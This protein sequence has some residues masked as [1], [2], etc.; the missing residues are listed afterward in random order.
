MPR[1]GAH[2]RTPFLVF[3]FLTGSGSET[4][5]RDEIFYLS[6]DLGMA[7]SLSWGYDEILDMPLKDRRWYMERL[8]KLREHKK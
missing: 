7:P 1:G 2:R 5:V 6:L 3:Q 4:A 8:L